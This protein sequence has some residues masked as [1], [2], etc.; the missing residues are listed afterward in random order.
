MAS[1][2]PAYKKKRKTLSGAFFKGKIRA[3]MDLVKKT[4]LKVFKDL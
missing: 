1:D 3:M 2:D 4:S